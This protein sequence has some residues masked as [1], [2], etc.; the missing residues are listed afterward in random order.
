M[1][2]ILLEHGYPADKIFYYRGG[3]QMWK[4]LGFTT[5]KN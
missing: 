4:I 5:V 3:F 1:I 2:N